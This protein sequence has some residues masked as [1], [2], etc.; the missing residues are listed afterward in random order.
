MQASSASLYYAFIWGLEKCSIHLHA[1]KWAKDL[2]GLSTLIDLKSS[3]LV[4]PNWSER[5]VGVLWGVG[6]FLQPPIGAPPLV[7]EGNSAFGFP[8]P[9][10][11]QGSVGAID[12]FFGELGLSFFREGIIAEL[13]VCVCVPTFLIF[14]LKIT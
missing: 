13:C 3:N 1:L 10:K 9:W 11:N 2:F 7:V 5:S 4:D 12:T 14:P 6:S 8:G